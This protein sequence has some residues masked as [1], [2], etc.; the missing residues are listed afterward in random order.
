MTSTTVK[1]NNVDKDVI[2][3]KWAE[4]YK[5][6]VAGAQTDSETAKKQL[7][8]VQ[9]HLLLAVQAASSLPAKETESQ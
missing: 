5:A 7:A 3:Q 2:D 9:E 4:F 6:L 8:K 1:V